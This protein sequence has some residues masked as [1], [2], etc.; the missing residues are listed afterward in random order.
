MRRTIFRGRLTQREIL[1]RN[2]RSMKFYA[3][4]A[5]KEVPQHL[6]NNVPPKRDRVKRCDG[7]PIGRTEHQEQAA[8]IS[9]WWFAS[10]K[11]GI[12][13]FGLFAV[14][15]GGARDPI[16]GARLKAEGVRRGALDLILAVPR[17]EHHGLF[18]EMKVGDNKPTS[19]QKLFIE[20][21][22]AAGYKAVA[23]WTADSAIK[24]IEGYLA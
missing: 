21:L 11:Y 14:P 4:A 22:N 24:E 9:W 18:I 5:D 15:N 7:K 16:T 6:L 17:K 19:D 23:H 13:H 20:Y 10:Q 8:V 1:E 2:D 3:G 12:P